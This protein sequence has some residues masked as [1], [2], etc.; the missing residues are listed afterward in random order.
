[1]EGVSQLAH[2]LFGLRL[3]AEPAL[4]GEVWHPDVV[5]VAAYTTE[6]HVGVEG[7]EV[8][9]WEVRYPIGPG[10]QVGTIYCDFFNRP[11][12]LPTV[13]EFFAFFPDLCRRLCAHLDFL[14][15]CA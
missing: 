3:Q 8:H 6:S 11:G 14:C 9:P 5:K 13:R 2:S 10:V 12:K 7:E 4:P 15:D 1:M